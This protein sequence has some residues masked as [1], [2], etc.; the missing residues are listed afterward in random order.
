M[1]RVLSL[2]ACA[3]LLLTLTGC[4]RGAFGVI[5]LPDGTVAPAS[6]ENIRKSHQIRIRNAILG[7]ADKTWEVGVFIEGE[8]YHDPA[9]E[10]PSLPVFW[11]PSAKVA[12]NVVG[13]GTGKK[14]PLTADDIELSV[15]KFMTPFMDYNDRLLVRVSIMDGGPDVQKMV[16]EEMKRDN[17]NGFTF[18]GEQEEQTFA[19]PKA[20]AAKAAAASAA[21]A[22]AAA[23]QSQATVDMAPKA[24]GTET[25][26][27]PTAVAASTTENMR[28]T[29]QE[30]D[31]LA[32]ISTVFYG[33]P[34]H[35][36]KILEANPGTTANLTAG[37]ELI[38]PPAK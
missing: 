24:T 20:D 35:W 33:S 15:E 34:Q 36:R 12:I 25:T 13:D 14:F 9:Q 31:T 32:I 2:A 10:D 5:T 26:P 11:Y 7:E 19:D 16:N 30:G 1:L 27:A 22:S 23:A 17:I 3:I 29:V 37:S 21:A 18:L 28:Y 6:S 4:G 38:I 8:P